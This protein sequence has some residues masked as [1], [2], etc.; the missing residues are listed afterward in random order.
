VARRPRY[1][2][3][4]LRAEVLQKLKQATAAVDW[5]YIKQQL[6]CIQRDFELTPAALVAR[7]NKRIAAV[8]MLLEVPSWHIT[9]EVQKQLRKQRK[10]DE[11]WVRFYSEYLGKKHRSLVSARQ[12][13]ILR[14]WLFAGGTIEN[15]LT[16]NSAVVLFFSAVWEHISG[17]KL[18]FRRIRAIV[19]RYKNQHRRSLIVDECMWAVGKL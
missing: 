12:D 5:G 18:S 13:A 8:D 10:D 4:T 11:R 1:K 14:T 16:V 15:E 3:E 6:E 2:N 17:E 19:H 7:H 9:H